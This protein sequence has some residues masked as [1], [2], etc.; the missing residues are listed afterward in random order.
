MGTTAQLHRKAWYADNPNYIAIFLTKESHSTL[1]GSLILRHMLNNYISAL[2]YL[3]IYQLLYISQLLSRYRLKVGKVKAKTICINSRTSLIYLI[4]YN[5]LQG[6]LQ[7]MSCSM[8]AGR[9]Q[10][11]SLI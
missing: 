10:L 7:E 4:T 1:I 11:V 6:S 8:I 2:E 9:S 3:L 5:L